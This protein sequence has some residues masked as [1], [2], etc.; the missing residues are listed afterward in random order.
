MVIETKV[1]NLLK[2]TGLVEQSHIYPFQ[3]PSSCDQDNFS[4]LKIGERVEPWISGEGQIVTSLFK[5]VRQSKSYIKLCNDDYLIES[6]AKYQDDD[7]ISAG[8]LFL[9]D[10]QDHVSSW[11]EREYRLEMK[12]VRKF[13][14]FT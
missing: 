2:E 6:V 13:Q 11:N 1:I 12:W 7:V 14:T 10:Y 4:F 5:L 9:S 3:T 8:L